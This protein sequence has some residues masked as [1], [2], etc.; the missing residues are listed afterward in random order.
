MVNR[1]PKPDLSQIKTTDKCMQKQKS[2]ENSTHHKHA[3]RWWCVDIA[4]TIS[5]FRNYKIS[6]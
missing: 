5:E 2:E 6:S 3:Q 4:Q 1:Y